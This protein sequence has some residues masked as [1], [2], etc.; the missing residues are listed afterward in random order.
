M[1]NDANLLIERI[2]SWKTVALEEI[3]SSPLVRYN[4][5]KLS[6]NLKTIDSD[7]EYSCWNECLKHNDCIAVTFELNINKCSLIG[8]NKYSTKRNKKAVTLTL[9]NEKIVYLTIEY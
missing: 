7:S 2:D 6:A 4:Q 8:K 9:E 1:F 5:L 3:K